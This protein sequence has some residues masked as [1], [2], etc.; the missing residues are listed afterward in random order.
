MNN[1]PINFTF[2]SIEALKDSSNNGLITL[3]N[4]DEKMTQNRTKNSKIWEKT[5]SSWELLKTR[6]N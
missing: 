6:M 2:T 1:F 4:I 5:N 3:I